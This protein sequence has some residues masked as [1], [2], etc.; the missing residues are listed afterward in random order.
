MGGIVTATDIIAGNIHTQ[1]GF[2][3][4]KQIYRLLGQYIGVAHAVC[5][6]AE[7]GAPAFEFAVIKGRALS[8][9]NGKYGAV[10]VVKNLCGGTA[11]EAKKRHKNRDPLFHNV[12]PNAFMFDHRT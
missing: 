10:F 9:V 1:A 5:P 4:I 7:A 12:P 2:R 8:G 3:V 6:P 11:G